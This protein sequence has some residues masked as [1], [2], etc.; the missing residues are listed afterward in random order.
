MYSKVA[1]G[2]V[3]CGTKNIRYI[4]KDTLSPPAPRAPKKQVGENFSLKIIIFPL[5]KFFIDCKLNYI[6]KL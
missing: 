3:G 2:V 1:I 4:K 6:K 5:L